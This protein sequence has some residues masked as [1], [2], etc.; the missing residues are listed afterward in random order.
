MVAKFLFFIQ[1]SFPGTP[2]GTRLGSKDSP[3]RWISETETKSSELS[4]VFGSIISMLH[5]RLLLCCL[6]VFV[7]LCPNRVYGQGS[8]DVTFR[9]ILQSLF[10]ERA[11]VPGSFNGWGQPY[12]PDTGACILAGHASQMTSVRFENYWVHT[13]RLEI[14]RR[15]NPF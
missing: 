4:F 8:L 15:R 6:F 10:A 14:R 7:V 5:R 2:N 12:A 1:F 3:T 9:F 11:F 13:V